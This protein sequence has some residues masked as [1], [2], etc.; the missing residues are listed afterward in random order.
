MNR[1]TLKILI[2]LALYTSVYSHNFLRLSLCCYG[3]STL[4]D[5]PVVMQVTYASTLVHYTPPCVM[6]EL[7]TAIQRP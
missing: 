7:R 1:T 6:R 3:T 4:S 2:L 5:N